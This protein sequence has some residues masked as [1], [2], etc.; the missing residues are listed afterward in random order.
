MYHNIGG[1]GGGGLSLE[2]GFCFAI[3]LLHMGN[4]RVWRWGQYK[5]AALGAFASY[6]L[7]GLVTDF[8]RALDGTYTSAAVLD[9]VGP[10]FTFNGW[11]WERDS[12]LLRLPCYGYKICF[13]PK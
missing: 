7:S 12:G 13:W 1:M 9:K 8:T 2:E 10:T 5:G 4:T 6:F 3:S 11:S